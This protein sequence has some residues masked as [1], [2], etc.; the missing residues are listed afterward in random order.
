MHLIASRTSACQGLGRSIKTI[1]ALRTLVQKRLQGKKI[2]LS[3]NLI[4]LFLYQHF[5][6]LCWTF[7]HNYSTVTDFTGFLAI[8]IIRVQERARKS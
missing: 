8:N 7:S 2:V 3:T 6:Y 5:D 4:K 1:I